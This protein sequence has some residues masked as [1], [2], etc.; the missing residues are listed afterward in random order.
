MSNPQYSNPRII[1]F[2]PYAVLNRMEQ[3]GLYAQ[4]QM[5]WDKMVMTLGGRYDYAT[6]STLTRALQQPGGES[7]TAVQLARRQQP[8]P[9]TASRTSAQAN[10]LNRYRVP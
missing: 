1:R 9:I 5:E 8:V 4:D 3:T 7:D 2:L 6:T 10:R